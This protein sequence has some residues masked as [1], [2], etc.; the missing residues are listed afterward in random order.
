[1]AGKSGMKWDTAKIGPTT[2]PTGHDTTDLGHGKGPHC[3]V[4]GVPGT[5]GNKIIPGQWGYIRFNMALH[6]CERCVNWFGQRDPRD[7]DPLTLDDVA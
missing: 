5:K 6:L 3:A 4:C 7:A 1:M 2:S